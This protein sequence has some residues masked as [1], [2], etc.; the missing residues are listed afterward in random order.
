MHHKNGTIKTPYSLQALHEKCL[1]V[2]CESEIR[3]VFSPNAENTDQNNPEYVHFSRSELKA[4]D[5]YPDIKLDY[6]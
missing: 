6:P 4:H 3:S 1:Y 2:P 5:Y